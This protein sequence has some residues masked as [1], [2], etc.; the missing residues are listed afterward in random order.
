MQLFTRSI[1]TRGPQADVMA[2]AAASRDYVSKALGKDVALWSV[3]FG[4][5]LGTFV[6]TTPVAGIADAY[7]MNTKLAADKK[8]L[9]VSGNFREYAVASPEDSLLEP[10]HGDFGTEA[11]VGSAVT[12]TSACITNGAYAEAVAWGI[13]MAIHVE[14]VAD[15]PVTFSMDSFGVFGTVSWV[16]TAASCAAADAA[17]AALNGDASYIEKLGASGHLFMPGSGR[18]GFAVRVA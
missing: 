17:N 14:K 5:P 10:L 15:I 3:L 11:P 12:V 2:A 6:Y 4:G 7:A 18:R 9:E 13:D 1:A 8:F 16:G